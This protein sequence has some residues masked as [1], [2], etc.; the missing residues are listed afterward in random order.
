MSKFVTLHGFGGSGGSEL[1]FEVVGG[2]TQPENPKENT[3]W[4]NTDV[5]ISSWVFS[6]TEP[7]EPEV[8]IVWFC[9]S[10]FSPVE[11][12]ALKKNTLQVYPISAKQYVSNEWKDIPVLNYDGEE[13]KEWKVSILTL[14]GKFTEARENGTGEITVKNGVINFDTHSIDANN[15][16]NVTYYSDVKVDVSKYKTLTF[17]ATVSGEPL[18][19]KVGFYTNNTTVYPWESHGIGGVNLTNG[20][21]TY[22]V[23]ISAIGNNTY[24]GV[25]AAG[26]SNVK[27]I[28]VEVKNLYLT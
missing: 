9:I 4:V 13:W 10:D 22:A 17:E 6:V 14:F 24:F 26:G 11:F 16:G 23:D 25:G 3:I 18:F 19:A 20:T 8:G 5:E 28:N 15:Q 2:T 27:T 7:A 1:N 12:N 21:Q